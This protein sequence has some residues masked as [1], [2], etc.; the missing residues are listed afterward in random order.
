MS[1]S[2]I[3][4]RPS[5]VIYAL[6]AL[7]FLLELALWSSFLVASVRLIGGL[8]GWLIGLALTAAVM[9]CGVCCCPHAV[10]SVSPAGPGS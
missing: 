10:G 3:G 1:D 7:R 8:A 5:A 9:R 2:N 6:I 4:H